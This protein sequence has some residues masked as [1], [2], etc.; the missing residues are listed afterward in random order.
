MKPLL[1]ITLLILSPLLCVAKNQ[2]VGMEITGSLKIIFPLAPNGP[3]TNLFDVHLWSKPPYWELSLTAP[4]RNHH[5]FASPAQVFEAD[6]FAGPTNGP[7]NTASI[8]AYP[9]SQPLSDRNAEHVWLALLTQNMFIGRTLPLPLPAGVGMRE[10]SMITKSDGNTNDAS[11]RQMEWSN[12]IQQGQRDRIEGEFQWLAATNT[13]EGLNIPAVSRMAIYF[14][15]PDGSRKLAS[16]SELVINSCGPLT[17]DPVQIPRIPGRNAVWDYR[18]D[19]FLET[20]W[21]VNYSDCTAYEVFNGAGLEHPPL[22]VDED[23]PSPAKTSLPAIYDE[24]VDGSK[25]I[26][27]ALTLAARQRKH[28]LL[29]FGANWCGSCRLLHKVFQTDKD[30]TA[31]LNADYV[32][33][34]IDV[35]QKHNSDVDARYGHPTRFGL[36]VIVI[37][38]A[39][40]KLLTTKDTNGFATG[41][42]YFLD[43]IMAFLKDWAPLKN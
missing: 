19:D 42:Y 43:R 2:A 17:R 10:S 33:V 18:V 41:S 20:G 3:Q 8:M 16:L 24:S 39:D 26:A 4:N 38:D 15:D 21:N 7:L 31:E 32:T 40:G 34:L 9:G 1:L 5:V 14:C 13:P 22:N 25:L 12:Q 29:Q 36:P 30:I 6:L 35:N 37:L 23:H 11:P 28:V 27:D